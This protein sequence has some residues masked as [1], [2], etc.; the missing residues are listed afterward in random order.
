[1]GRGLIRFQPSN[2]AQLPF[3]VVDSPNNA[4]AA[5]APDLRGIT[6]DRVAGDWLCAGTGTI[7]GQPVNATCPVPVPIANN[8]VSRR[9]PRTNE[10]RPDPRYTT[11]SI[12]ANDAESWYHGL[13]A[14]W[15][16]AFSSG[17]WFNATYT[18]SKAIDNTSEATAVGAGDSN[19]LGPDKEFARGLSRFNTPHRFTFNGTWRLPVFRSRKDWVGDVLGGWQVNAIVKIAHGTPF[20][21]VDTGGGDINWDGYSE[22]RP[23][24][25]DPSILGST[26]SGVGTST[27]QLP[28]SAFRR[29]TPVAGDYQMLVGR[30]TFYKDG[31]RNM[32]MGFTKYFGMIADHRLMVRLNVFNLLNR[33]EWSFPNS[34]LASTS[35]GRITSQFNSPRTVQ[36]EARYL[37]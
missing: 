6:I 16:K 24:I 9:V 2:L 1:M 34:D 29:S 31:V 19:A 30:N 37:F 35:F 23:V 27:E 28:A 5:G 21:V 15:N 7:P 22:N 13:Q 26:I 10:R 20:T 25:L 3:T 33:R 14:E 8:E 18:W 32:D 17:L 11:N 4:P 12:I 36:V